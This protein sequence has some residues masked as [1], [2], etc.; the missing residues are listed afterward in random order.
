MLWT[1][2]AVRIVE[3]EVVTGRRQRLQSCY[4]PSAWVA[5]TGEEEPVVVDVG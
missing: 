4:H 5:M 1:T 3:E 2:A